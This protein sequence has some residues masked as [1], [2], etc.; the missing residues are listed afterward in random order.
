MSSAD[1]RPARRVSGALVRWLLAYGTFGIPQAA[2]PIAFA[3]VAMPLT[4]SANSGA[5]L[6]LAITVA[7]VVGAVPVVRLGRGVNAV[8]YF[9]VLVAIRAASLVAVALLAQLSAP[10]PFLMAAAAA[11]G[12][13]NGAA[14]GLLRSILNHL[15]QPSGMP[16]A[17]GMAATLNEFTFVAA[18]AAAAILSSL[19][20]PVIALLILVVLGTAP[21]ML[22]PAVPHAAAPTAVKGGVG[23]A[24]PAIILWLF[25]TMANSAVVSAVEIGAVAIAVGFGLEPVQGVIFAVALCVASVAGGI[26]VSARNQVPRPSAVP[27]LLALVSAGA[28]L[29]AANISVAVTLLGAVIIGCFLAPLGTYYSLQ[30]DALSPPHRKAEVFALSRTANAFGV[31]LTSATLTWLS[32]E[33][34]MMISAIVV[35]AATAAVAIATL[36]RPADTL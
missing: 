35:L 30:L 34:T 4:G 15:V 6:V 22:V 7:Q 8:A 21:I 11:G 25:C 24:Q 2:G 12:F 26:W 9:R 28:A 17:L 10:F 31:I 23:V 3:L 1:E 33:I 5:A 16:R 13:V 14:F 29:T 20:N 36:R 18:P 19:L 27:V 32:I